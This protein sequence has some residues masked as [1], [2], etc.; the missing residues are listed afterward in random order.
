MVLPVS[1][2]KAMNAMQKKKAFEEKFILPIKFKFNIPLKQR[3]EHIGF[4]IQLTEH[5][6]LNC[7]GCSHFSPIAEPEFLDVNE[8]ERDAKRLGDLAGHEC[9][10]IHLMGGEPL[11][12]PEINSIIKIARG[13]FSKGF[14]EVLTNGILLSQMPDD[15]WKTCHDYKIH[16]RISHYPIN[17][18]A[19]K[20]RDIAEKFDVKCFW[21]V[22]DLRDEFFVYA[23]DLDGKEDYKNNFYICGQSNNCATLSHGRL[24]SCPF[25]AHVH[26]FNKKFNKNIIV[27]EEDYIDIYSD[28]SEREILRRL[29]K[30]TPVCRFCKLRDLQRT[31]WGI[32]KKDISEWL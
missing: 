29:T 30:A 9:D 7:K 31:T 15:F 2:R 18:H 6:N 14:I 1:F 20:I 11:L 12:H 22:I 28:V 4:E 25:A 26:H 17:I 19:D 21:D 23:I 10:A 27:T 16:V 8:F 5:C 13:N 24:Y 32:S 3:R